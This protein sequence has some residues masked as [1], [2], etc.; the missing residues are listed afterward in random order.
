MV[1]GHV[2]RAGL[3]GVALAAR[4]GGECRL[5]VEIALDGELDDEQDAEDFVAP[6]VGGVWYAACEY[7]AEREET[8]CELVVCSV[9]VKQSEGDGLDGR[10]GS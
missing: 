6:A 10:R 7:V 5:D 3:E 8:L 1:E 4:G 2:K 9:E